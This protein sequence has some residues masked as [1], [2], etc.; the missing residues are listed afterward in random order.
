M[1]SIA[2]IILLFALVFVAIL[3]LILGVSSCSPQAKLSKAKQKVLLNAD[4]RHE[5][6]L[7]EL[8]RFPC[9]NDSVV[10]IIPTG[11]DSIA[12]NDYIKKQAKVFE[13]EY[14]KKDTLPEIMS[15]YYK[16]GYAE[17]VNQY[18]KIKIPVC[19]PEYIKVTV[20]DKQKEKILIDSI[21]A[22]NLT[23]ARLK[24]ES[25]IK[26]QYLQDLTQQAQKKEAKWLW[27]FIASLVFGIVSNLGWI[28]F[29]IKL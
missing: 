14:I 13:F 6:F 15:F 29:K 21:H 4:A 16:K 8:E 5:V 2:K 10:Q 27:W 11:I 23:V 19:K 22:R 18:S 7:N 25:A 1:R 9:A 3:G 26:D 24:G 28:Y 20:T 17:A 12:L